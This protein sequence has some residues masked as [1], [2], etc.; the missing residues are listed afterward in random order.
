[1]DRKLVLPAIAVIAVLFGM[2]VIAP[3]SGFFDIFFDL[4]TASHLYPEGTD[5]YDA[6]AQID[7]QCGPFQDIVNL[8][9]TT[10]IRRQPLNDLGN[11]LGTI[12]TEIVSLSLSG[13]SGVLGP[14][15]V[16][17]NPSHPSTGQISGPLNGGGMPDFPVDSFFDI[18]YEINVDG[19]DMTNPNPSRLSGPANSE[20]LADDEH[21]SDGEISLTGEEKTCIIKS[22]RLIPKPTVEKK[23]SKVVIKN[24]NA[25]LTNVS[26]LEHQSAM[27]GTHSVFLEVP[28]GF[29]KII[30]SD[31]SP[32]HKQT[33][34]PFGHTAELSMCVDT[35]NFDGIMEFWVD[36][37]G[38]GSY[39]LFEKTAR[40]T[41]R[42]CFEST[43]TDFKLYLKNKGTENATAEASVLWESSYWHTGDRVPR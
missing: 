12:D 30:G 36:V 20:L 2:A 11:H 18:F 26:K 25:V 21:K 6:E 16:G 14:V 38:D 24:L 13:N 7:L 39:S 9:G 10:I 23:L 37:A 17:L 40:G 34:N 41:Q 43:A 4:P 8:N 28:A 42:K 19:S 1:M 15:E 32:P 5:G 29:L 27:I 3:S 22:F 31:V 33:G 35:R